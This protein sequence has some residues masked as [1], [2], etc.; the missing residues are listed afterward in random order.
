V[1]PIERADEDCY[2]PFQRRVLN[3]VLAVTCLYVVPS[4]CENAWH[5]LALTS[6]CVKSPSDGRWLRQTRDP[7]GEKYGPVPTIFISP[8]TGVYISRL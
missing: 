5:R 4:M 2:P 3:L 7:E 8:M 6:G 1:H